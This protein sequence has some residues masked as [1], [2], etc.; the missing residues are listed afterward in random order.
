VIAATALL[1]A[2][3]GLGLG[4]AQHTAPTGDALTKALYKEYIALSKGEYS[5][6]DYEDSDVFAMRAITAASGQRRRQNMSIRVRSGRK[7]PRRS[8]QPANAW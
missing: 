4:T 6:G 7:P 8:A 3:G 5:E 1:G 2:C